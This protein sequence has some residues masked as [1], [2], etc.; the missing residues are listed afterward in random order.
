MDF[1]THEREYR[2]EQIMAARA[3]CHI[4]IFGLGALGSNLV[5][6]LIKLGFTNITGLDMDRVDPHNFGNQYYTKLDVGKRKAPILKNRLY[7]E[8]GA[9]IEIIDQEVQ[10]VNPNKLTNFD[11]WIDTFDNWE[12]RGYVT[13]LVASARLIHAGMSDQGYSEVKWDEVYKIPK[14]EA[15]QEDVCE[16]P[17]ACNLV[18]FTV[19]MLAE[20][21]CHFIDEGVKVSMSFTLNDMNCGLTVDQD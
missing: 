9:N 18:Y 8:L 6:L 10:K 19:S 20:V 3:K 15:E 7:R 2:D 12:A 16:Y 21:V 13:K 14:I 4:C 1:L 5:P 17:L 11:L